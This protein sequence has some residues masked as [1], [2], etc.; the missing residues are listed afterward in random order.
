LQQQNQA[1]LLSKNY[2]K[3][4]KEWEIL[5]MYAEQK[6]N[7]ISRGLFPERIEK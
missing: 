6:M 3:R 5:H 2:R 1:K 4:Y 7:K